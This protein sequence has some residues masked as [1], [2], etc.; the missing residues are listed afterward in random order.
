MLS[1]GVLVLPLAQVQSQA[2]YKPLSEL[3][4]DNISL[5]TLDGL[6]PEAIYNYGKKIP[7]IKTEEGIEL[8][9]E[10]EFRLL[11]STTNPENIDELAKLYTIEFM[12]TYDLN[13]S[14]RGHKSRL[15]NQLY[16]LTLK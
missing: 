2:D 7:S 5:Y 1:I 8:P 3:A 11:T 12:A 4:S 13:F 14:D 6:S 16:K 10:K 15:V 9:K